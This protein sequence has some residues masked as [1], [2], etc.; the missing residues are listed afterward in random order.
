MGSKGKDLC[1]WLFTGV[2]VLSLIAGPDLRFLAL[3]SIFAL[4][5]GY[6]YLVYVPRAVGESGKIGL[7]TVV[8]LPVCRPWVRFLLALS[9]RKIPYSFQRAFEVH[10]A[11]AKSG[12][13]NYLE[14]V[15]SDLRMVQSKFPGTLFLWETS[16]PLPS[17]IRKLV[18]GGKR[19][20]TAFLDSKGWPIPR[21]PFT[22]L[23]LEKGRIRRGAIY[24]KRKE[25]SS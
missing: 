24:L 19:D 6:H 5:I 7:E 18:R 23:D 11:G 21:F 14:D 25:R 2:F 16:A 12:L 9:G 13:S 8:L 20:G 1:L 3:L 15:A 4:Y 17:M 10:V 22:E